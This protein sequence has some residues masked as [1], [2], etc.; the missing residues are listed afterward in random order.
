VRRATLLFSVFLALLIVPPASARLLVEKPSEPAKTPTEPERD[1]TAPEISGLR[2]GNGGHPWQGDTPRFTTIS[3][4]GDGLRDRAAIRF[5]LSESAKVTLIMAR[6]RRYTKPIYVANYH[7][8]RGWHT[9]FWE[10]DTPIEPNSYLV[11]LVARDKAGN[12]TALAPNS[13]LQF[14]KRPTA[15]VRVM[16]VDAGFVQPNYGADQRATINIE[17][18]ASSLELQFFRVG[19]ETDTGHSEMKMYGVPVS[20][21]ISIGWRWKSK[22]H[23]I[24]LRIGPWKTGVYFVRLTADDGRVGYAPFVIR[25]TPIG[26]ARIAVVLPAYTWQAYNFRDENQDGF[27]DTWYAGPPMETARLGRIQL[28]YGA[29]PHF[30]RYELAFLRWLEWTHQDV[31]YIT[32]IDLETIRDGEGLAQRYDLMVWPSHTEYETMH[33]FKIMQR[34]RD[35]G[36]NLIFLSANNFFWKI[37]VDEQGVMHRI[38]KFRELGYPEAAWI[39]V[40][41]QGNDKGERRPPYIVRNMSAAP[42]FW[43]GTG[44]DVG[45]YFGA[46]GI[47]IDHTTKDSPDNIIVLAEIPQIYGPG[48]T[49]QMT[50]YETPQG[51]KV[52][53]GGTLDFCSNVTHYPFRRML[54]N[55]W[56]RLS[57]P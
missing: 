19:P 31:D 40:G 26:Q 28:N 34:Y 13:I 16:G 49:A 52:F 12:R 33:V 8:T 30:S 23:K 21:P 44:L 9:L 47:E 7:L 1:R 37:T 39:G 36:G 17:T 38:R 42:W 55:L 56:A 2:V 14:R 4:N 43:E 20:D 27:G 15:V 50:Y 3:P 5:H 6:T 57:Q 11:Q 54:E 46:N 24:W 35:L 32:D 48:F 45:S 51:A 29:P 10:P 41:Y 53:A 25:P 18:D 22:L